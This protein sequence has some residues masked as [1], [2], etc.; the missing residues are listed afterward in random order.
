M[1]VFMGID[2]WVLIGLV[3]AGILMG[4]LNILIGGF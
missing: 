4:G 1:W 3:V 2:P